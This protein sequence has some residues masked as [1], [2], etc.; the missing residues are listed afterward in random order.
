[1]GRGVISR[2][3]YK[4]KEVLYGNGDEVCTAVIMSNSAPYATWWWTFR[5]LNPG[6]DDYEST[7]LTN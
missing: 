1:M 7:A 4:C 3:L 2:G 5:D 6:P